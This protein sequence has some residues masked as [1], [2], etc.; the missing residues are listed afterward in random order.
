MELKRIRESEKALCNPYLYARIAAETA[1][2]NALNQNL[3]DSA[4]DI[5]SWLYTQILKNPNELVCEEICDEFFYSGV[6]YI[7]IFTGIQK[8]AEAKSDLSFIQGPLKTAI[9]KVQDRARLKRISGV[10]GRI[11]LLSFHTS[12]LDGEIWQYLEEIASNNLSEVVIIVDNSEM[13]FDDLAW[14]FYHCGWEAAECAGHNFGAIDSALRDLRNINL[15]RQPQVLV[16]YTKN[17]RFGSYR[18]SANA[19]FSRLNQLTCFAGLGKVTI[20]RAD[21]C[22]KVEKDEK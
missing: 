16:A 10:V 5:L 8:F 22:I 13:V 1:K 11:Y 9:L 20:E 14:K 17:S 18:E 3:C 19:I 2:F 15:G 4:V 6:N 21:S 7:P 12:F